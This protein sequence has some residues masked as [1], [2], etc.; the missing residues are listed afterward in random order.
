MARVLFR[1]RRLDLLHVD[2]QRFPLNIHKDG[3]ESSMHH[4]ISRGH[5]RK[6]RDD[7]LIVAP[8]AVIV[9]NRQSQDVRV[10]PGADRHSFL[11]AHNLG[12]FFFKFP[13]VLAAGDPL[14]FQRLED[15]FFGSGR[16][17]NGPEGNFDFSGHT[18]PSLDFFSG[19]PGKPDSLRKGILTGSWR[20]VFDLN[21]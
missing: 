11:Y 13:H 14:R 17:G 15:Q 19:A 1:D 7:D 5:E 20:T 18:T 21:P 16:D 10:G 2:I 6:G 12:E 3:A 4:G 9:Q 8:G